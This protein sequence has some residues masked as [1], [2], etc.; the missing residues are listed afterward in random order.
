ML[1]APDSLARKK[2]LLGPYGDDHAPASF[3]WSLQSVPLPPLVRIRIR[4]GLHVTATNEKSLR[5]GYPQTT[6]KF[7]N[8]LANGDVPYD[9]ERPLVCKKMVQLSLYPIEQTGAQRSN[10]W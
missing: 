4:L 5:R 3:D 10:I 6:S 9:P 2:S 7:E 1:H 8:R